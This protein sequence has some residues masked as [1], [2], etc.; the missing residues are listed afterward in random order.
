MAGYIL[1]LLSFQHLESVIKARI[2]GIT[3]LINR[4][5]DELE[6]ELDHLGRP[7]AVDAGVRNL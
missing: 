1:I 5:I 7:V 6:A 4:S 3:S 2:P